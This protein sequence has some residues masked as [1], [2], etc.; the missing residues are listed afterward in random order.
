MFTPDFLGEQA[1]KEDFCKLPINKYQVIKDAVD[2][3]MPMNKSGLST[4]EPEMVKAINK[5]VHSLKLCDFGLCTYLA[6]LM[7]KILRKK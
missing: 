6:L 4:F 5:L 7:S 2:E 3:F 1:T